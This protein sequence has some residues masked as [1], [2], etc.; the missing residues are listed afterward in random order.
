MRMAYVLVKTMEIPLWEKKK[1]FF[2]GYILRE[3]EFL[4]S[5]LHAT[6]KS[7]GLLMIILALGPMLS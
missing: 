2:S 6:G 1:M 7:P 3:S 5:Y 4:L